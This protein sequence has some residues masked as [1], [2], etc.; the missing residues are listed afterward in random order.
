MVNEFKQGYLRLT[1]RNIN[2]QLTFKNVVFLFGV[3]LKIGMKFKKILS[4]LGLS[5]IAPGQWVIK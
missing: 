2:G 5:M 3:V 1:K 4:K